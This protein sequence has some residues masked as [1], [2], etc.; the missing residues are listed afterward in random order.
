MVTKNLVLIRLLQIARANNNTITWDDFE[1]VTQNFAAHDK[2]KVIR[3]LL[4][5]CSRRGINFVEEYAAINLVG[6]AKTFCDCMEA[7][8]DTARSHDGKISW[9]ELNTTAQRFGLN[10]AAT[11]DKL[12][13][14]CQRAGI[15]LTNKPSTVDEAEPSTVDEIAEELF[16]SV[17]IDDPVT[18]Y[19]KE[20]GRVP[21]LTADEEIALCKRMES[22]DEAVRS[23]AQKNFAE[24]N[25][26]LVV[27]IAKN[28]VGRGVLFLDLIQEGNLGLIKA[29]E[30]FDY[31]KGYK[32]STYA[33]WWIYQAITLAIADQARTI[34]I[35]VHIV[36]T[37]NKLNRVSRN[38]LYE[39]GYEPTDAEIAA[40]MEVPVG[41]VCEIKKIAQ[42]PISLDIPIVE[43]PD[44]EFG[45]PEYDTLAD[46]IVYEDAQDPFDA[47]S[48]TLLKEEIGKVLDTLTARE[49][50]VLML[51]FGLKD[52]EPRTLEEVGKSFNVDSE[53]IRQVE[54]KALRK[55]R[56]SAR[57]KKLKDFLD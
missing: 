15:Q 52:G 45:L 29:V 11:V 35:P 26:R 42:E 19:L 31:R 9:D 25:L 39:N 22:A 18:M 4:I 46:Y 20:I 13:T 17:A 34:K 3:E 53:R 7:L 56:H 6:N 24:A 21:L 27:S 44:D 43:E 50:I 36:E 12:S 28:Y 23:Q 40:E 54:S 48:F 14:F 8:S 1:R 49:K 10:D 41:R 30:K 37:I 32:F 55:L 33:I 38:L 47:V 57:S 2:L 16:D 5:F 51:R